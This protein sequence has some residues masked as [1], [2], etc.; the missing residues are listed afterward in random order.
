V[1][2]IQYKFGGCW[3]D[4]YSLGDKISWERGIPHGDPGHAL[5]RVNGISVVPRKC[6]SCGIEDII[7]DIWIRNDVIEKAVITTWGKNLDYSHEFEI[8]EQSDNS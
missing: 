4:V 6:S 3:E 7:F 8:I 5:V 2:F 1:Y